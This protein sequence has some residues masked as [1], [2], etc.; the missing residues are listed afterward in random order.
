MFVIRDNIVHGYRRGSLHHYADACRSASQCGIGL[1][2]ASAPFAGLALGPGIV[3]TWTSVIGVLGFARAETT[4]GTQ[5][6]HGVLT[7]NS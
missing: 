7:S 6:T 2:G 4:S 3:A 5:A 1:N